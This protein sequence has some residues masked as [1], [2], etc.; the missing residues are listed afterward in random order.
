MGERTVP[1]LLFGVGGVGRALLR[2]IVDLRDFHAARYGVRLSVAALCDRDGAVLAQDGVRHGSEL[3][4]DELLEL[5]EW[6]EGGR[7]LADREEGGPQGDLSSIVDIAGAAGAV[8]V[9]CTAVDDTV[10]ALLF[11][12]ARGY[13]VALANKKPLTGDFDVY[14]LL[15]GVDEQNGTVDLALSRWETTVGAGLPVIA[16]LN[17]LLASGDVITT[18]E[19]T[20]S[21]TLGYVMSGLQA[22]QPLSNVVREAHAQGFT[23]PDPRDDLGGID[24]A[25]KALIL[26]RGLG[27]S[28]DMSDVQ[29]EGLY[30][31]EMDRL[32]VDDFLAALPDLD[33]AMQQRVADAEAQGNVVRYAA[34]VHDGRCTVGPQ[35]V[36]VDSPLGRLQGTDNLVAFHSRWY[37]P[38]PLVI[39]GRGA[40]VDATAAGVLSDII[41][42]TFG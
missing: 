25:R 9:D 18:I 35:A 7:R 27:W 12:L 2:Q 11:A 14:R 1:V 10:P 16:T 24:V 30:P 29:V 20:F 21:G 23:E 8:I 38:N 31:P 13:R 40:G 19:G 41:E 39:Q 26:A 32:S 33:A 15:T 22:G 4:D 5:A 6:K 37:T 28:L 34:S 3:N 36:A 42:L 17:R